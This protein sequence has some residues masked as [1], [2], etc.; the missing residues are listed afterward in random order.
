MSSIMVLAGGIVMLNNYEEMKGVESVIAPIM[1]VDGRDGERHQVSRP[2][3]SKPSVNIIADRGG[4]LIIGEAAGQIYSTVTEKT[5]SPILPETQVSEG[6]QPGE[7]SS[8]T[9]AVVG[10]QPSTVLSLGQ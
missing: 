3:G 10:G 2:S 6:T 1:L 8:E 5:T 4:D 9:V 7:T